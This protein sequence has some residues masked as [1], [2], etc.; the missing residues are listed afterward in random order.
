MSLDEPQACPARL[1]PNESFRRLVQS[2]PAT[3][4]S[5]I[6]VNEVTMT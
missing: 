1:Y 3:P 4:A 2:V 6:E 5:L